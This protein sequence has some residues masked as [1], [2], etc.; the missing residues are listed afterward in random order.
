MMAIKRNMQKMLTSPVATGGNLTTLSQLGLKTQ[1][2]GTLTI[3][4]TVLEEAISTNMDDLDTLLA[5]GEGIE[6]IAT[7]FRSYLK[8]ATDRV[9]GLAATR[10][11]STDRTQ[12]T[13]AANIVKM[14]ARLEK[15]EALLRAQ[16]DSMELLI[17]SLNSTGSYLTQQLSLFNS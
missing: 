10:Q 5:G 17:S 14:E 15:R 16:F 12:K 7:M 2:D 1:K 6:G 3:D 8:T 13:I 9:D 11:V 4:N